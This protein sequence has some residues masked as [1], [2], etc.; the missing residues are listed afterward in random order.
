MPAVARVASISSL[1]PTCRVQV[2]VEEDPFPEVSRARLMAVDGRCPRCG[3]RLRV[4]SRRIEAA[5]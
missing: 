2:D 1:C 4:Y 3:R 5:R